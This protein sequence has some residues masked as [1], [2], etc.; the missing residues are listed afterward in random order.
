VDPIL[1]SHARLLAVQS[2]LVNRALEGLSEDDIWRRPSE[3]TNS[4]GWLLGHL[5]AA[6]NNMLQALGGEAEPMPWAQRFA[7]GA[8]L[9]DRAAYP[10]TADIV[11]ALKRVNQKLKARMEVA[12]EAE[13][14]AECPMPNPSPD[15]TVRGVVAFLTFHDAYHV[16]PIAYVLTFLGCPGLVG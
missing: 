4:I 12:T 9:A 13:L 6:R 5:A 10:A 11:G 7:R 14:A 3:R 2:M 8:E 16:G 15:K 1:G